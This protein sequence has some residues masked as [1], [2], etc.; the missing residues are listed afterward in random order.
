MQAHSRAP[1]HPQDSNPNDPTNNR[2]LLRPQTMRSDPERRS[3][4][5]K[6]D[7]ISVQSAEGISI[8]QPTQSK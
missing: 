2:H 4:D 7:G 6:P 8:D 5:P 3:Q 1:I